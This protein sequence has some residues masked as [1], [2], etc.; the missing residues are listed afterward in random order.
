MHLAG[1]CAT[2]WGYVTRRP[3]ERRLQ[4]GDVVTKAGW[5]QPGEIVD[6]NWELRAASVRIGPAADDIVTWPVAG[7][8]RQ[9]RPHSWV[10]MPQAWG[11]TRTPPPTNR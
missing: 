3:V 11:W 7:L 6:I 9:W 5:P 1:W 4:R 2:V 8:R 10:W